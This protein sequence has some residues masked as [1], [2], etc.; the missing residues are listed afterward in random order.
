MTRANHNHHHT[1][2]RGGQGG[3]NRGL[4]ILRQTT[5]TSK[6]YGTTAQ[7]PVLDTGGGLLSTHMQ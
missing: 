3:V 7:A 5:H 2:Y 4:R 6:P 1:L